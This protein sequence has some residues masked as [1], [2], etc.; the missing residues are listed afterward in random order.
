MTDEII[1]ELWDTKDSI[2][3][4]HGYDVEALV[5]Y[6]RVKERQEGREVVDLGASRRG[7]GQGGP[8]TAH[9]PEQ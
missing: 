2:A 1:R 3:R 6:L 7:A 9:Q 5:A 8:A 4:D